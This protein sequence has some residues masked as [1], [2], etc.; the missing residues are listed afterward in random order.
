MPENK[1]FSFLKKRVELPSLREILH[2]IKTISHKEKTVFLF[3]LVVFVSSASV[4]LW[5]A[6]SKISVEV[7]E[8]GGSLK[9]GVLGTPRFINPILAISDADR[10][11]TALI[12]SG[13]MRPDNQ[14]GLELDMAENYDISEDGLEYIF[15]LK[16]GLEWHDGRPVTSDDIIFTI[17]QAKDS[18][19]K[20]PK[21]ASWEGV[22]VEKIS[23]SSIKF[24]LE[25][26]YAPFLDNATLGILPKHLWENAT[27]ELM[28]FSELNIRPVGSGP[29]KVKKINRD[30]S[31]IITSAV[32]VP[33]K[34]FAL[35]EPY[36]KNIN[37][38]F[39][40]S[41][42]K[43]IGAYRDG[44]IDSISA[45]NPQTIQPIMKGEHTIKVFSLPRVF[46]VFFNQNNSKIFAQ[47]EI[48][49]ALD[50][51]TDRQKIVEEVLGGFG[52]ELSLP[53]PPGT[54]GAIIE[55]ES[56]A[57]A[58][59]MLAKAK[60]LLEK[61]GWKANE[62][63]GVLEKKIKKETLR[64]EFSISTAESKELKQT[65]EIIKSMWEA[66]GAKIELRVFEI[67][68]LNQNV[69]RPRKYDSLLFGE[70]VGREPD[71]FAFWHSSQRNDPGLNIALYANINADKLLEKARTIHNEDER[72]DVYGQFQEEVKKDAP[73]VF[74]YSPYFIYIIP[75]DIKGTDELN[76]IT[77][78]SER[79]SQVHKWHI[80]TDKVWKIF[81]KTEN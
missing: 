41:E 30:S 61:N 25:K 44:D 20:S 72:R 26:A 50:M 13:L 74:L 28:S 19:V 33:N 48:R 7:A 12:Y 11:M 57:S 16:P 78:P 32:L 77:I 59:E 31:G 22:T 51:A 6:N 71:P 75:K 23:E 54:F 35:G 14:G 56:E 67:G 73:A 4:F 24:V 27:A 21:R 46:G 37:L 34:K 55:E 58:E 40:P 81:A 39:Y 8:K 49:K 66:L 62:D 80:K 9:E 47:E 42:E 52:T 2:I 53:I 5:Q 15:H 43:L 45:I 36:I 68:D 63:D 79:F 69:I 76:T 18:L 60:E 1:F 10:D 70:V 3:L 64:I 65:A 17:Q 38:K 29:Y